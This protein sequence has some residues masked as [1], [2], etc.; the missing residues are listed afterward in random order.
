MQKINQI[1]TFALILLTFALQACQHN[2]I[3]MAE[4][5]NQRVGAI[6]QVYNVALESAA[7][8]VQDGTLPGEFRATVQR[9]AL[10]TG[11]IVAGLEDAW[12]EYERA[13]ILLERGETPAQRLA[14]VAANL[15]QWLTR[16]EEALLRLAAAIE[17][18]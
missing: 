1:Q 9:I 17:Q 16:G 8:I 4:T 3:A 11:P 12:L 10:E 5:P 7:D 18:K 6:L 15:E 2:P 13:R 14:I